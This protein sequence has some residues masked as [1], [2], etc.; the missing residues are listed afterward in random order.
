M[1]IPLGFCC[2][3]IVISTFS[4]CIVNDGVSTID[5]FSSCFDLFC[6]PSP[7]FSSA[8]ARRP[9]AFRCFW[10]SL[11]KH[12]TDIAR[13]VGGVPGVEDG[14]PGEG[15]SFTMSIP[16]SAGPCHKFTSPFT[17]ISL[18]FPGSPLYFLLSS[19]LSC[20]E[21]FTSCSSFSS[22][23]ASAPLGALVEIGKARSPRG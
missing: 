17:V 8:F 12:P 11:A 1:A 23:E 2:S 19:F 16:A 10:A 21:F 5:P 13:P 18:Q 4:I 6:L 7:L 15:V 14:S 22:A 3:L 20:S 9:A